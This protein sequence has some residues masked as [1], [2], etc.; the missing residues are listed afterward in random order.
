MGYH[1]NT[2]SNA[3]LLYLNTNSDSPFCGS[4]YLFEMQVNS[5]SKSATGDILIKLNSDENLKFK[6]LA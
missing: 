3:G 6:P 2:F 1:E 5:T 4:N